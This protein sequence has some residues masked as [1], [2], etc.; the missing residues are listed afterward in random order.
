MASSFQPTP[1]QSRT[2]WALV[3]RGQAEGWLI[4]DPAQ[5]SLGAVLGQGMFGTTYL[6]RWRGAEVAVKCVRISK[7][8][9]LT[10]FIREV[11]AMS[12]VRSRPG[13]RTQ[14]MWGR[15]GRPD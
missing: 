2:L 13:G 4:S 5:V 6:G 11:E 10:T 12:L 8:S 7:P 14:Q 9:E 1:Q 3:A 15:G